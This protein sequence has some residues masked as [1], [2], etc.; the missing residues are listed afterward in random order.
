MR[1]LTVDLSESEKCRSAVRDFNWG[2]FAA[3]VGDSSTRCDSS[4]RKSSRGPACFFGYI[5]FCQPDWRGSVS[6]SRANGCESGAKRLVASP[7]TATAAAAEVATGTIFLGPC[8]VDRE[9]AAIEIL[10][11]QRF[12]GFIGFLGGRHFHKCESAGLAGEFVLDHVGR[13]DFAGL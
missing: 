7:T 9:S 5:L 8:D 2:Y 12:D 6:S 13:G 10:A 1:L 3:S 4:M 11:I